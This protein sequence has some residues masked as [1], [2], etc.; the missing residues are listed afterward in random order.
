MKIVE[1]NS[2]GEFIYTQF[3][4]RDEKQ[5]QP[6]NLHGKPKEGKTTKQREKEGEI[7][8]SSRDYK[9]LSAL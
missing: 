5:T 9:E 4:D 7:P 2:S 8:L 6:E 1:V 3:V